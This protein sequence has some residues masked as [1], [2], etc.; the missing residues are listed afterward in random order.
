MTAAADDST[1]YTLYYRPVPGAPESVIGRGLARAVAEA[2][3]RPLTGAIRIEPDAPA[4]D[5]LSAERL[6]GIRRRADAAT[7]G[8]WERHEPGDL[9]NW[10]FYAYLRGEHV[11][12]VGWLEF[13]GAELADADRTF[14]IQAREDVPALLAEVE[15]LRAEYERLRAEY[16]ETEIAAEAEVTRLRGERDT[17]RDQR[18]GEA[19]QADHWRDRYRQEANVRWDPTLPPGGSVCATCGDPV[20]SEPCPEHHPRTAAARLRDRV[21]EL[22]QR[23]DAAAMTKVWHTAEGQK[24][25]FVEDLGTAL[26]GT[27]EAEMPETVTEWGVRDTSPD[28]GTWPCGGQRHAEAAAA[29]LRNLGRN[30]KAVTHTVT[31][32]P[33]QPVEDLDGGEDQ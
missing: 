27:A 32:G 25:V 19:R 1:T 7:P 28:G 30:A 26:L 2:V 8:P 20:E 22:E 24:F 9:D 10:P 33:W 31:Y 4:A 15:R 12:G 5:G 13:G 17:L 11:R 14:V 16:A 3:R 29:C 23:L 6:D 18:N 21:A